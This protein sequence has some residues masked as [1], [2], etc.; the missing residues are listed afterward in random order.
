M[1]KDESC[2]NTKTINKRLMDNEPLESPCVYLPK[3]CKDL[4]VMGMRMPVGADS[5]YVLCSS[6]HC[7]IS[8][9]RSCRA[10][11]GGRTSSEGV[12][13]AETAG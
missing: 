8:E 6:D 12:L 11:T 13:K 4:S 7:H 2:V 1:S 9:R 3:L 5:R 10:Q